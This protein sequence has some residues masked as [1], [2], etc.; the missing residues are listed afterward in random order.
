MGLSS[1]RPRL[2][3][4]PGLLCDQAL[5]RPQVDLLAGAADIRVADVTG[6]DSIAALA[7]AAVAG[8]EPPFALAGLSMGGYVALEITLRWPERV[9]RLA[10]L[11][12]QARADNP[13]Q[14]AR[15]R[16]LLQLARSGRFQGVTDRL[17]PLLIHPSRLGEADLTTAIKDMATRVGRDA[18]IRQQTAIL[19]RAD[20]RP[21]LARIDC[22]TLVLCGREDALTPLAESEAMAI[23]VR[24]ARLIVVEEC[25]HLSTLERP[26]E[27][28][29]ALRGW[30][31][32]DG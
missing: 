29:E 7:E 17:L 5:W 4:V 3:L 9:E 26:A 13:A 28:G 12:T 30:L 31:L 8:L 27:V 23:A 6:A 32:G 24:N 11:D 22:P 18:F 19:A 20:R 2:L 14:A 21:E 15:R 25:G 16:G 10:L 1:R